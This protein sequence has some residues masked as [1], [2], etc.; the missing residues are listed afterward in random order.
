[1][2]LTSIKTQE[3][4][5]ASSQQYRG[6]KKLIKVLFVIWSL[7][8][9]GAERFLVSLLRS[10]DRERIHPVVCCLNWKGAWA[11]EVEEKDIKVIAL[12][13]KSGVDFRAFL[14]LIKIMKEGDFDI[15]NTHLWTADVMGRLAAFLTGTPIVISTAQN[16]DIWKK[17]WHRVIDKLLAYR[18]N[19]IIA[20]SEAVKEYYHKQVGIPLSKIVCIPNAIETERYEK[21]GNV[22][23]LYDELKISPDNFVLACIGRLTHQKGHHYLLE[24]I[25]LVQDSLPNLRVL[26]VG[27]GE[28]KDELIK[29]AKNLGILNMIFFMGYRDDIAEILHLSNALVLPS[30]YEGLP[31]CVLEAMAAG[32]P[33]IATKVGGT[34]KLVEDGKTGVIVPPKDITAMAE[35]IRTV[36]SLPDRGKEMGERGKNIVAMHFSVNFIAKKTADLFNSL[37]GVN[38]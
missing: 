8:T 29:H 5:I 15:V 23:Y 34:P 27:D 33:V 36:L 35:A 6:P 31:L 17:W 7:E 16:V 30:L 10:I 25:K 19:K 2:T 38:Q 24:S 14:N 9:G 26:F 37:I 28:L 4:Y 13:K 20:V 3:S 21:P 18:T 22:D 1:M 12:H 32:R 11:S